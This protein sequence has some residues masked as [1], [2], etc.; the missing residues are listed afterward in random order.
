MAYRR[1]NYRQSYGGGG[2]GYAN[3]TA[4]TR[5]NNSYHNND[6]ETKRLPQVPLYL[7]RRRKSV[8]EDSMMGFTE[9]SPMETSGRVGWLINMTAATVMEPS[10][11]RP[12]QA[13]DL[14]FIGE[15]GDGEGHRGGDFRASVIARPYMYVGAVG[16]RT[17]ELEMAI[18]KN[19]REEVAEVSTV[20]LEDTSVANHLAI[21]DDERKKFLKVE[22]RTVRELRDIRKGLLPYLKRT[23]ERMRMMNGVVETEVGGELGVES[24]GKDETG[25][26]LGLVEDMREYDVAP[27]NR[28]A[29]DNKINVGYWYRVLP[30]GSFLGGTED[31]DVN[32][33]ASNEFSSAR[34]IKLDDIVDRASPVV[35]AFDIECTKQPLQFPDAEKGDQVMM[36]SWM[37]DGKGYLGINREVVSEDIDDFDHRPHADYG[38]SFEVFNEENEKELLK[39]FFLEVRIAAPRV[40]VTFNGDNFDWPFV[41]KRAYL[42]GLDMGE[43]IGMRCSDETVNIK[44]TTFGRTAIHMDVF[45]WVTRD[46]Y[47]PFGSRGLKAVT[48]ALLGF[49]PEELNPEEM[50]PAAQDRPQELA[51]YSVSDA[52]VTYHLYMKYVHPFT[53]SLCNIIPLNPDDV[54]RKGSGTL[55]EMLL[56]CQAKDK[57]II[58]PNKNNETALGKLTEDGHVLESETYIGGHVEALRTGIYRSD[59]PLEFKIETS[60][61]DDLERTLD[62]TLKFA[63]EVEGKMSLASVTNYQEVKQSILD[64][65]NELRNNPVRKEKP[66]IYHL[67]VSAMYPNIILTNRLQPH[68]V[69]TPEQCA[70]CDFNGL[71]E[72]QRP[73]EWTWRGEHFPASRGEAEMVQR[74]VAR[75]QYKK[76]EAEMEKAAAE[77]EAIK[78]SKDDD[79][80]DNRNWGRRGRNYRRGDKKPASTKTANLANFNDID[81]RRDTTFR[82]R[83]KEYCRKTYKKTLVANLE[84]KEATV[85]QRENPFYVDTVRAF[86]DRRYEYKVLLKRQKRA[87]AA[88]KER[89]DPEEILE[90][91]NKVVLYDSLQLAHKCILNSFYGYVMRRGA[92]WYSMEM[93]GI[94]THTGAMIIRRAREFIERVGIPLELDT[95]GI[96]CTLPTSFPENFTFETRGGK[97]YTMSYIC[98]VFNRD[99][100]DNFS[101]DQYQDLKDPTTLEYE[102]RT[103]C[104]VL[105]EVDGPY[106]AMVLPASLEKGKSIKK[107]YA[108]FNP[109]GSIAE[110]KGF[111]IKRRG[112]LKLIKSFQGEIFDRFLMGTTIEE[113]YKA[114]GETA[115]K[116]LD[117]LTS[118]GEG[119]SDEELLELLVEQNNMSKP[120]DAYIVAGQKSC[121]ITCARRMKDILGPDIV[122]DK[123]VATKY[124]I[125]VK[126]HGQ[127]VTDRAIPIQIFEMS[128]ED[129]VRNLRKWTQAHDEQDLK[130][131]EILDWSYYKGRLANA[132][133]KIVSIP[134]AL[135]KLANPVPRIE[136]PDWLQKQCRE[137][138]DSRKQRAINS[139]FKVL[140]A[141]EKRKVSFRPLDPLRLDRDTSTLPLADIEDMPLHSWTA[142]KRQRQQL[143]IVR[144]RK[145]RAEQQKRKNQGTGHFLSR[146]RDPAVREKEARNALRALLAKPRPDKRT[147]YSGWLS[148]AKKI[149]RMQRAARVQRYARK[150]SF[151]E[152]DDEDTEGGTRKKPKG[153]HDDPDMNVRVDYAPRHFLAP[154]PRGSN[155]FR[156]RFLPLVG[157]GILW[158]IVSMTENSVSG[159]FRLWVLPTTGGNG[160]S[161]FSNKTPGELHAVDCEMKRVIYLDCKKPAPPKLRGAKMKKVNAKLPRSKPFKNLFRA[162]MSETQFVAS[163]TRTFL[164]GCND[165]AGVYGSN[166]PL[167]YDAILELGTFVQSP[168]KITSEPLQLEKFENVKHSQVPYLAKR[169]SHEM[170]VPYVYIY[171]SHPQDET[172]RAL[173]VVISPTHKM[174]SVL[175]V[176]SA[177]TKPNFAVKRFWNDCQRDREDAEP[178]C[179]DGFIKAETIDFS[180]KTVRTAEDAWDAMGQ[181]LVGL[182]GGRGSGIGGNGNLGASGKRMIVVSQWMVPSLRHFTRKA[183]HESTLSSVEWGGHS[184]DNIGVGDCIKQL[185]SFPVIHVKSNNADARYPLLGWEVR[186]TRRAFMRFAGVEMW[187]KEQRAVASFAE[188]PLGNLSPTDVHSH[189][190]DVMIGRELRSSDNILWA[191]EGKSDLGGIEYDG[192]GDV[193]GLDYASGIEYNNPGCYRQICVDT[194]VG[195]L[196]VAT[197]L[198]ASKVNE[199]EGTDLAFDSAAT[200]GRRTLTMK[201]DAQ[202]GTVPADD[203]MEEKSVGP[204]DDMAGIAPLFRILRD[205]VSRWHK[206]STEN[207]NASTVAQSMLTHLHRWVGSE[208]SLLYDP[209]LGR[210]LGW[211]MRKMFRQLLASIRKLGSEVIYASTTRLILATPRVGCIPG[212]RYASF[213]QKTIRGMPLFKHITLHP[214][215]G[216]YSALLFVDRFNFAALPTPENDSILDGTF[217]R[218]MA[219][220]TRRVYGSRKLPNIQTTWDI[221]RYLP[222]QV[223]VLWK[224]VIERFI[225]MPEIERLRATEVA[226]DAAEMEPTTEEVPRDERGGKKSAKTKRIARGDGCKR[227][228]ENFLTN[229]AADLYQKV[230]EIRE[231]AP[232]LHFPEIPTTFDGQHRNAALEFVRT[233]FHVISLDPAA[234]EQGSQLKRGLLRLLG[235]R[236]FAHDAQFVDPSLSLPLRNVICQYCNHVDDLDL[237]RDSRLWARKYHGHHNTPWS[238]ETCAHPYDKDAIE[239]ALVSKTQELLVNYQTQDL[240]CSKCSLVKRDNM[241]THCECSGSLYKLSL[242]KDS[243][244]RSIRALKSVAEF[245]RFEYLKE[246]IDWVSESS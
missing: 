9:I 190:L 212:L 114:V 221:A 43:E 25:G 66:L 144:G 165:I 142:A 134:A 197:I 112:E 101:N 6:N 98:S 54:L 31:P 183:V 148:H 156:R 60:A 70:S 141:G 97:K 164:A 45:H 246:T 193:S 64:E 138:A 160:A 82:K 131:C 217:S 188:I 83:L 77:L 1:Q 35:L 214:I 63:I 37:V 163:E 220:G 226:E 121:A 236:E 89:G 125:G 118:R 27:V 207:G 151:G 24:E 93:A 224:E 227:E 166:S 40:F 28:L 94:V 242:D 173:Y 74:V 231:K 204:L 215:K 157:G 124:V 2:S 105:F 172:N 130:L 117:I 30:G 8:A 178:G 223:G 34:L 107:R 122:K 229:M 198:A 3:Y 150:R 203:P 205:C 32:A 12:V 104:S 110:L 72:C 176:T 228:V 158:Q 79:D 168:K 100:A 111:E 36:I 161:L 116:F 180:I 10:S 147:N 33:Q 87:L 15:N 81:S 233:L 243:F 59:L 240:V 200:A 88:A 189:A 195:D 237:T 192:G 11:R 65:L 7:Q 129:R 4:R 170:S 108:V 29:I 99:V 16:D 145:K 44:Q 13:V 219:G 5:N 196:A 55:C 218:E 22:A 211:L 159:T 199:L 76:H 174:V 181:I 113:C 206:L 191:S 62:E 123:G 155:F 23:E 202:G 73:M 209:V 127:K 133:L 86:R 84:T 187:L 120:L 71:S 194:E 91:S 208:A 95:D 42:N 49:A 61:I 239:I 57:G 52:L 139:F 152:V 56:M 136:Y 244:R 21:G 50:T 143:A 69:V 109:N 14:F 153:T 232:M 154:S 234:A 135:Q 26:G 80:D 132:V 137:N 245:H 186:A 102:T 75:E 92:R 169:Q 20:R 19:F 67:D 17:R 177:T 126:P 51:T 58:A 230:S 96:W 210:F 184:I 78:L 182:R 225:R 103:E 47:L 90:A 115:D 46:S 213:L 39:R 185:N 216:V 171:G 149:W 68:A 235:V 167:V 179:T 119:K 146:S 48:R 128:P 85:C 238:C 175:V 38:S 162:E 201:I 222:V 106:R 241:S 18:R 53:F 41:D 140:P